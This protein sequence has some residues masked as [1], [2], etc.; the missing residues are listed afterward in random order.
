MSSEKA[1]TGYFLQPEPVGEKRSARRQ[2]SHATL[3]RLVDYFAV[4]K[5]AP[6]AM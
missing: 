4:W 1:R 3:R 5:H 6:E 2:K